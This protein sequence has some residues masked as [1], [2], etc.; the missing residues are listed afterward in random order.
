MA[1]ARDRPSQSAQ[2]GRGSAPS[3]SP[4]K[5]PWQEPKLTFV[6]PTLTKHGSLQEVTGQGFFG[7][8]TPPPP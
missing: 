6:E 4:Y 5:Q 8:F 1:D 7:G 3:P 2:E